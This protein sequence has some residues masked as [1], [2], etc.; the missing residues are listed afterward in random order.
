MPQANIGPGP[1][2]GAEVY[3]PSLDYRAE[4]RASQR[5]KPFMGG[6][7]LSVIAMALVSGIAIAA[8]SFPYVFVGPLPLWVAFG[9]ALLLLGIH[10][11][12]ALTTLM[13][14]R[15]VGAVV[16]VWLMLCGATLTLDAASNGVRD[17]AGGT[18]LNFVT[19]LCFVGLVYG[20]NRVKPM[21]ILYL[22]A[23][24]AI[25]QGALCIL[26]Y[27]RIGWAW[28]TWKIIASVFPSMVR[29]SDAE[30][31]AAVTENFSSIGRARGTHYFVHTF[32]SVIMPLTAALIGLSVAMPGRRSFSTSTLIWCAVAL[33]SIGTILTFSR[34]G[35]VGLVAAVALALVMSGRIS[36]F[37][38]LAVGGGVLIGLASLLSLSEATQFSR[39]FTLDATRTTDRSRMDHASLTWENFSRSP[40]F[41]TSTDPSALTTDLPI[42]SVPLRYM[43]DYGLVGIILYLVLVGFIFWFFWS[44]RKSAGPIARAWAIAGLCA[45]VGAF[46]DSWT[47]SSG[48]LRRDVFQAALLAMMFG[49]TCVAEREW[50]WQRKQ[51]AKR[52]VNPDAPPDLAQPVGRSDI[53]PDRS[54]SPTIF[55]Q[56]AGE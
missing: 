21:H 15:G 30:I 53:R 51:M 44:R 32:N 52:I 22:L 18:A 16:V 9:F 20:A 17:I 28:N 45:L 25:I 24:V 37:L 54:I 19:L 36:S 41:G 50:R 29:I 38:R 46:A 55:G 49:A 11:L 2:A 27:I 42:H 10:R 43:N 31:I 6:N 56:A 4:R 47:H 12:G 1:A 5:A 35:L 48:L 14:N 3:V 40:L 39:L 26:Q 7:V 13:A 23:G 8:S 33:G 34:S